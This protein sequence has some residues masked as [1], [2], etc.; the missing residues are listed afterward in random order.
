MLNASGMTLHDLL[1]YI[2]TACVTQILN[3]HRIW[4]NRHLRG[5]NRCPSAHPLLLITSGI[6]LADL[7]AYVNFTGIEMWLYGCSMPQA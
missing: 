6:S 4:C 7:H 1:A 5:L 2:E 3:N